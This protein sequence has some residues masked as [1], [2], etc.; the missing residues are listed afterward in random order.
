M[1]NDK[2]IT[3]C[4][5]S[6]NR[7][8]LLQQTLDTFFSLNS[9][10]IERFLITEDS[11]NQEMKGKILNRYGSKIELIFN[12]INLG[13]FKTF[14]N[15]YSMVDTQYIFH[16]EDDWRFE[17]N[18][19]F[20]KHSMDILEEQPNAHQVWIRKDIEQSW[21]ETKSQFTSTNVEYKMVK[22]PHLGSWCGFSG[23]PSLKRKSDYLKMFPNGYSEFIIPNVF[24]GITELNCNNHAAQQG[25]RAAQLVN[26]SIVH[27]GGG[28][29]TTIK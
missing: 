26:S 18:P 8:D 25:Y 28:G 5:A 3:V 12:D 16:C 4:L 23:N 14:D 20:M 10:P 21:I 19:N 7:F 11:T 13:A 9:F 15:M 17:S 24:S 6:C 1:D 29:R 22:N 27:I 2:K